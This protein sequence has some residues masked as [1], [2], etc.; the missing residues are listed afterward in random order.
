MT[1]YFWVVSG[2]GESEDGDRRD[3]QFTFYTSERDAEI[4][5]QQFREMLRDIGQTPIGEP[6]AE[7][8]GG[9]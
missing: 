4:A 3:F 9:R 1:Q 2:E 8:K 5:I 7:L 6:D